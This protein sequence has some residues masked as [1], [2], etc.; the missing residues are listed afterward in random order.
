V[1]CWLQ[2]I[3]KNTDF[4][5]IKPKI[6]EQ[7]LETNKFFFILRQPKNTQGKTYCITRVAWTVHTKSCA[8][9]HLPRCTTAVSRDHS[10][11]TAQHFIYHAV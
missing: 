6:V 4:S 9:D 3:G 11:C 8:T 1:E 10:E 5:R 2:H 7:T